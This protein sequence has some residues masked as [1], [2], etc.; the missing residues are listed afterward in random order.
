MNS[1]QSNYPFLSGGGEMGEL[2]RRYDWGTTSLGEPSAWPQGLKTAVR[3]LLSA[4]H[5][6][7][8]W[9]GPEL[10]QFYNDG[11]RRSIGLERHPHAL[12]QC[13]RECWE[14]IWP[15]IGPQIDQVM[16]G[17]GSTWNENQ[18]VPITRNGKRDDVYWTYS[19]NPID[20]PNSANGIGGVLVI[21]AETTEQV[22]AEQ[23]KQSAEARWRELFNQAPGFMC[24]LNGPNHTYEFANPSYFGLLEGRD[25]IGKT[26]REVVP[27]AEEQGFQELLDGV[28][29]NGKAHKGIETPLTLVHNGVA[30]LI[31]MDFV[32]QPIVDSNGDVTGIFVD[33]YDVTDRVLA[34]QKLRDD[35]RRKDEFLAM[36]AHE[37]RNPLAPIRNANEL[38]IQ[39]SPPASQTRAIG[40]LVT[41]QVKQLAHLVDDLLDVSRITRGQIDLKREPLELG[42][43]I[44]LAIESLQPLINEKQHTLIYEASETP[45]YIDGDVTR[46]TQSIINVLSNAAKYTEDGG[47]IQIHLREF[48][49]QAII[50][51]IDNGI[52]IAP[53]TLPTI[54]ELFV[55]ADQTL[56]R[57]KGGLGIGLSIVRRL[58]QMHGG[59]VT[60]LS[61]GI[62]RGS[63]FEICLPLIDAPATRITTHEP[64]KSNKM[65]LL[66][67]DDNIDAADSMAMLLQLQG[68][69][70]VTVYNAEDALAQAKI[71]AADVVLLDIG[72]P[73]IDGYEVARR[74][75]ADN[76]GSKLVALTGYGKPEDI[77]RA[78]DAGFDMHITKPVAFEELEHV[79]DRYRN[80]SSAS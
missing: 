38:L 61:D 1:E 22:L 77:Q 27:E 80:V 57:S 42:K 2:I 8:I 53:Q 73:D 66:I 13:G 62:G 56:D 5:P 41:R 15:I 47:V 49:D 43:A 46:I 31:Y 6:M 24:I 59:H 64:I 44:N 29:R 63:S 36:L 75:R 69:D 10:I 26:V 70:T 65:R 19:Y 35:E 17:G 40:E 78:L 33:G 72:L 12:G 30:N 58:I 68:H 9:W 52:G 34:N 45:L 76:I 79:L 20:E 3:L 37:L 51:I 71:L 21:C 25:L 67:V 60:A 39:M 11:Y 18:L 54:F 48:D 28:Y 7:F 14:E 23:R 4:G 74:L 55:Q 16:T 50:E 32:Y